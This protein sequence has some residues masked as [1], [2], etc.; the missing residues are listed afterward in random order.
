MRKNILSKF[1]NFIDKHIR[2]YQ[3]PV[4]L[5]FVYTFGSLL[6]I[7][8]FLQIASGF[9]LSMFY[10]SDT[11]QAWLSIEYDI[12]REINFGWF[13]RNLHVNVVSF[14]FF[15]LYIH[16]AKA[17][18]FRSFTRVKLWFSGWAIFLLVMLAAFSGYILVWGQMSL[19]AAT[20]ITNFF[21]SVPLIGPELVEWI[22]GG[23]TVSKPTLT[24][25][26]S[27]HFL[28][29][30]IAGFISILHIL[31]L[32]EEG[33]SNPIGTKSFD[34]TNFT[35]FLYKDL[36]YINIF[37][38]LLSYF[39]FFRPE[40]FMHPANFEKA[41]PYKT[42]KNIVPEWYF[43][44]F[45]TILKSIPYKTP[46][47]IAMGFSIVSL[48][49]LP[50]VDKHTMIKTP[51]IRFL[52]KHVFWF[53]VF[54]FIFLGWLGEQPLTDFILTLSRFSTSAYFFC[55]FF[56]IPFVGMFDTK[57]ITEYTKEENEKKNKL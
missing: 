56:L 7:C 48:I 54:N 4:N 51:A 38:F 29:G 16:L 1:L 34:N 33:S 2:Y 55:I 13:A 36:F 44:P 47:I 17:I 21:S 12:M 6:G 3:T 27:I 46:G 23:F 45:Y 20:V 39:V 14:M 10:N 18:Y 15:F 35:V 19:W 57:L 30:L 11:S 25:F 32:H 40:Y 53:F 43:L 42:P 9:F 5:S 41:D 24:R 37:F 28:S 8:M 31:V 52:W 50:F 22:W 49:I 26:F